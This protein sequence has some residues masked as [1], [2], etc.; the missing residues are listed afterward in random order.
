MAYKTEIQIGVKGTAALDKLRKNI[1]DLSE[2]VDLVDKGF[3]DGIQ[4]VD[5]YEKALK[6]AANALRTVR[7]NTD[8]ERQAIQNYV[9]ALGN[10]NGALDRQNSLIQEEISLRGRAKVELQ[11]YN[12]AAAAARPPGGSMSQRYLRPGAP[13]ATTQYDQ[14]IGPAPASPIDALVGQSSPV[15]GRIKRIKEAQDALIDAMRQMQ[16]VEQKMTQ[17]ELINDEKV[18]NNKLEDLRRLHAEELRQ[19]KAADKA[20]LEAFDKKL[21]AREEL[22]KTK[23]GTAGFLEQA[24]A[25]GLGAGFPLLFGGGVGQV[26]GGA[27]GTA[28][29]KSFGLAGEAAMGLQIAL[30]AILGKVE[31]LVTRFVEVGNAVN[32][33]D[34]DALAGTFI[35]VNAEARTLVR[36]LIE[37]GQSQEALYE[38]ARQTALQTGVL[39]EATADITNNVNLLSNTWDE[40]VGSV[41]GLVSIIATP[42]VTALTLILQLVSKVVQGVNIWFSL[43]GMILK[44]TGEIILQ[45]PLLKPVLEFIQRNTKSI[46]EEEEKGLDALIKS[47]EAL[48]REAQKTQRIAAIEKDRTAGRTAAEK[49]INADVDRRVKLEELSVATAEKIRQKREEFGNLTSHQA[50]V[51][52]AYQEMLINQDADRQRGKVQQ[53]FELQKQNIE[54]E[55]QREKEKELKELAKER[56]EK[57]KEMAEDVRLQTSLLNDQA[58]SLNH[59]AEIANNIA[60]LS[61]ARRKT[62]SDLLN[63]QIGRL[64]R[65]KEEA[66]HFLDKIKLNNIIIE[67]RKEQAKLEYESQ[68]TSIKL[69]VSKAEQERIQIKLKEQQIKLQLEQVRLEA[70][71]IQDADRR[72]AALGRINKQEQSTLQVVEDMNRA[73]DHSLATTRKIAAFQQQ[74]A[75]YA[76]QGKIEA[77]ETARQQERMAIF[78]NSQKGS[79]NSLATQ[80]GQYASNMERAAN[81]AKN[82]KTAFERGELGATKTFT[83]STGIPIDEDVRKAV[84]DRARFRSPE[85]MVSALVEAQ[86][87]RNKQKIVE[88]RRI[89][90]QQVQHQQVQ[91]RLQHRQVQHRQVQPRQVAY[92]QGGF[93]N[94]PHIGMVGEGGPEY[95][96]PESK[97]AA[98]ATNYMMGARGAAAIPRYAEG[99]Y[100][101]PI[102]VQTG[103]VMQQGGTN[104]VTMA[105]F[106]KGLMDLASS[107]SASNR[108]YGAR[109]YMGVQR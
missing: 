55:A 91:D 11:A 37:A 2:K 69:S 36:G 1:S 76:Y 50:Q 56:S 100:V 71:A 33:I 64:E 105:Q 95:I 27:I 99:G 19:I 97:A 83:I 51:E 49:L 10:A 101:G 57:Y 108:S 98:F 12:A 3:K 109:Q 74:S 4:S 78:L 53:T 39:P 79:M 6:E 29:A 7:I 68:L 88:E 15:E 63:L 89:E 84:L 87:K 62:E 103:P 94:R 58:T 66:K 21:K 54:L 86:K 35:T 43:I 5:R 93:V 13:I 42:F 65:Q 32:A 82:Q 104:Y 40:V 92:A 61:N 46:V 14:P 18:F 24:G 25:F 9:T 81:A 72:N 38:A 47:G 28:L 34:M 107:F 26:A 106:E 80:S 23:T 67:K 17:Q 44:K 73:A 52:L 90:S 31:E 85:E 45:I 22:K 20:E 102:N 75:K 59:Q 60:S 41:S 48:E 8:D 16:A 30:S 96:I 77:L 70:E